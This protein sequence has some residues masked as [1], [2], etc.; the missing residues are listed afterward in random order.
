MDDVAVVSTLKGKK[1]LIPK[2]TTC[3]PAP[4]KQALGK[5]RTNVNVLAKKFEQLGADGD[6]DVF[7]GPKK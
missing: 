2:V 1:H 5:Q 4:K 3:P 6:D 7:T